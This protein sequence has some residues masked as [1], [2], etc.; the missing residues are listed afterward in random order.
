MI[1][2][3]AQGFPEWTPYPG[4]LALQAYSHLASGANSVMYWHWHS[5][6]NACETYWKGILS[7]DLKPNRIY[8]E[9]KEIGSGFARLSQKLVNLKKENKVAILASNE[10]LTA[11]GLFPLPQGP[12][13]EKT[14]Y[15]DILRRWY[16]ALYEMN[17]E[18]DIL[19]PQDAEL[20]SQYHMVLAP[21]LYSAPDSLLEALVSYVKDGGVLVTGFKS[22]F[23]NEYV[24]VSHDAQPHILQACCGV[25]Y[26][27][28]TLPVGVSLAAQTQELPLDGCMA[29]TWMEILRPKGAQV[30]AT[31]SHPFWGGQAA[32]TV[33]SYGQGSAYYIGCHT[34][35]EGMKSILGYALKKAGLW[36]IEQSA[37][38]PQVIRS[39]VNAS[40]K[41]IR[42]YFNYSGETVSQNY[43]HGQG[44]ELISGTGVE[45]GATLTILPWGLQIFEE[46]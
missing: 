9:I 7:H 43:L 16:D 30:L 36:G 19:F 29:E 8:G 2:T 17:V 22:G 3:Q 20:L 41:N 10:S 24:K 26:D 31:Y 15:N 28:F 14:A 25:E 21:A 45:P 32:I 44:T 42:Y 18:C 5:I 1:E 34:G 12:Q 35:L 4:Q 23:T 27:E 40:G 6:H 46:E 38:F 13:G 39:G 37:A 33:N 11:I